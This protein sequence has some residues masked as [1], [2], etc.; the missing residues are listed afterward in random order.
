MV[1]NAHCIHLILNVPLQSADRHYTLFRIIT[2][3]IRVTSDK[4]IQYFVDYTYIGIQH[5][6]QN[7]L[8]LTEA[9]FSRCNKGSIVTCKADIAVFDSQTNTCESSFFFKAENTHQLCRRKLLV[10]HNTPSL[11][12]YGAI[13]VY[14]FATQHRVTLHCE[15][16]NA[17]LP[18]TLTLEGTGLLQNLTG[19]HITSPELHTFPEIHGTTDARI[20]PPTIYLPDNISVLNDHELQQIRDMPL[21]NLQRLNDIYSRVTTSQ[22]TYDLDAILHIHQASLR[23]TQQTNWIVIPLTS[24]ATIITLSIL[25]Y[26]LCNRFRNTYCIS[27]KTNATTS[28]SQPTIEPSKPRNEASTSSDENTSSNV[29]FSSYAIQQSQ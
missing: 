10:H 24:L 25:M 4:F 7:Y 18:R 26:F 9:S 3:P 22:H 14:Q 29:L 20:E 1:A 8:L 6:E 12:R 11:Q 27:C 17:Q 2:L 5:N 16:A 23:Q 21:P 13:W 28:P 15:K 19:C